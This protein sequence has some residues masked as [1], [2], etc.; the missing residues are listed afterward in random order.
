MES[1]GQR[2]DWHV[3]HIVRR[4]RMLAELKQS[5]LAATTGLALS[6]IQRIENQGTATLETLA[7]IAT[8]LQTTTAEITTYAERLDQA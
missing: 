2:I 4:L 1:L 8:A 6:K 5:D 3:G 7:K